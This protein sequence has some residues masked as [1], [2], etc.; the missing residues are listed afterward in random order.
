MKQ[1]QLPTTEPA[2]K[3]VEAF[4]EAE[5]VLLEAGIGFTVVEDEALAPAAEIPLAA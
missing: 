2:V 3:V 5:S 1:I 4:A